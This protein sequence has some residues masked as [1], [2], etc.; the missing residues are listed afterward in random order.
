VHK[1]A[2]FKIQ[3]TKDSW[4]IAKTNLTLLG[5]QIP[6]TGA[7]DRLWYLGG[8]ISPWDGLVADKIEERLQAVLERVERLALAPNQK[9]EFISAHIIPHYLYP[10]VLAAPPITTIR[11]LDQELRRIIKKIYHLPACTTNGLIS[12]KKKDGGLG[13][14]KLETIITGA[15]LKM[16]Q[17]FLEKDD[18]VMKAIAETSDFEGR[19]KKI[20]TTARLNW[21]L[22][23]LEAI[24]KYNQRERKRELMR[25]AQLT[26]QGKAVSNLSV[27]K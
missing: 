19:L 1:C 6:K 22:N 3:A 13:F 9:A 17:K 4:F 26:S 20:A 5:E 7:G 14:P 2:A 24:K 16:G 8:W 23:G 15:S 25:W 12:C 11:K 21:P 27:I 10:L 18:P